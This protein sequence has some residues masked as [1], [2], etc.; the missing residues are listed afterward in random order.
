MFE[1]LPQ[2]ILL[3][4]VTSGT[5]A[6]KEAASL[7][8]YRTAST[9]NGFPIVVNSTTKAFL[10]V[11]AFNTQQTLL[12]DASFPN[13]NSLTLARAGTYTHT[14]HVYGRSAPA[15]TGI[16][17][18][19]LVKDTTATPASHGPNL[20]ATQTITNS[21]SSALIINAVITSTAGENFHI[22]F[23]GG[24]IPTGANLNVS[25]MSIIWTITEN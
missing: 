4:V 5:A 15:E 17:A 8:F 23:G 10:P 20:L 2:P 21:T 18:I 13:N 19:D 9:N 22:R 12:G 25:I 14:I 11:S 3:P 1:S 16:F 7:Q 24:L 6:P